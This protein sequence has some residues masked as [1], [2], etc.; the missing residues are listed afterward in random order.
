VKPAPESACANVRPVVSGMLVSSA[1]TG[2]VCMRAQPDVAQRGIGLKDY[3][4]IVAGDSAPRVWISKAVACADSRRRVTTATR[5]VGARACTP[6]RGRMASP[7]A[8]MVPNVCPRLV[9]HPVSARRIGA[10]RGR[11]SM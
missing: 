6:E 3:K 2:L 4:M 9:R 1:G 11:R 5:W 7:S 10:V 8:E